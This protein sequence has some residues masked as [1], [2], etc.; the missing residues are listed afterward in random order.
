[1]PRPNRTGSCQTGGGSEGGGWGNTVVF[2][3]PPTENGSALKGPQAVK[4]VQQQVCS[5]ALWVY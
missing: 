1:M 4:G 5:E 2:L 3:I